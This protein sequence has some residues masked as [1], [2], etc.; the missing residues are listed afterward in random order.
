MVLEIQF[1]SL[2]HKA[3]IG[4]RKNLSNFSFLSKWYKVIAVCW[5]K[6]ATSNSLEMCLYCTS[7]LKLYDKSIIIFLTNV[8]ANIYS[9][10][11]KNF[12]NSLYLQCERVRGS[13]KVR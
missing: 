12:M 2:K 9:E 10:I 3:V 5:C 6:Q 8:L 4:L 11:S 7:L 1:R 13:W